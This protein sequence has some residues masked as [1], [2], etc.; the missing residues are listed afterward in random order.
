MQDQKQLL[1]DAAAFLLSCQI[2][3]LVRNRGPAVMLPSELGCSEQAVAL[4]TSGTPA[5]PEQLQALALVGEH[6]EQHEHRVQGH[7][8]FSISHLTSWHNFLT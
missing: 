8:G 4:V 3:G 2:P 6:R 1:K 5:W 7:E